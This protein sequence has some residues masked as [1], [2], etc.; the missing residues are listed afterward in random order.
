MFITSMGI[1]GFLS[2]AYLEQ[3]AE[4][5]QSQARIERI[6][7]DILRFDDTINRTEIKIAKLETE[8]SN[9]TSEIQ[10]QIDAEQLRM[11]KAFERV[12]PAINEQLE[13]INNEQRGQMM[14]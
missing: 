13:I 12:Q 14:K 11:D 1:F 7:N 8:T 9:D 5:Q 2:S 3:A 10:A 6:E 4:G